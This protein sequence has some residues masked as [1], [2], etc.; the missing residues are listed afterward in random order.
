[1]I[2]NSEYHMRIDLKWLDI[3]SK[4]I[5]DAI[6]SAT[7]GVRFRNDKDIR[8]SGMS[9]RSFA[10]SLT[11]QILIQL[12]CDLNDYDDFKSKIRQ[13]SSS[14]N[15]P[16]DILKN[17]ADIKYK[18]DR[19]AHQRLNYTQTDHGKI[20]HAFDQ[21]IPLLPD[22]VQE[23]IRQISHP[24]P[25]PPPQHPPGPKLALGNQTVYTP[26]PRPNEKSGAVYQP[27]PKPIW[28]KL[29]AVAVAVLAIPTILVVQS[30]DGC[31][32]QLNCPP[33]VVGA[34][35]LANEL[36]FDAA[37]RGTATYINLRNTPGLSGGVITSVMPGTRLI[38]T[39]EAFDPS[40][41][42]WYRVRA[43]DGTVGYVK[44]TVLTG[45]IGISALVTVGRA[46]SGNALIGE[47]SDGTFE[48]GPGPITILVNYQGAS[49]NSTQ[50]RIWIEGPSGQL[51]PCV[52]LLQYSSGFQ[53]CRYE[54]I[55]LGN[56]RYF[57]EFAGQTVA[58][59]EFV[60]ENS[61][62]DAA[63]SQ[64][65]PSAPEIGRHD[66]QVGI[67]PGSAPA[68]SHSDLVAPS[69][70]EVQTP[71]SFP[72]LPSEIMENR[73]A[74]VV[75][76][77]GIFRENNG[78]SGALAGAA[79]GGATG[80]M[81][82]KQKG[83]GERAAAGAIVGGIIGAIVDESKKRKPIRLAYRIRWEDDGTLFDFETSN[84]EIFEVN[85]LVNVFERSGIFVIKYDV[86]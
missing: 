39:H 60:I 41:V 16:A 66:D 54:L 44:D 46:M 57:A 42:R 27:T 78:R 85:S 50:S 59:G 71:S 70:R 33:I 68:D 79:V 5:G 29:L 7:R 65:Q 4:N 2:R 56:W 26:R 34:Q 61:P 1:M 69:P 12:N 82:G 14:G 30:R 28:R 20:W 58:N 8:I 6:T 64:F 72:T 76:V 37:P 23:K 3:D 63:E 11:E 9:L 36:Q 35:A 52:A 84:T 73:V 62:V 19:A 17:I 75:S 32:L 38:A 10:E 49:A 81:M 86:R 77:K 55:G 21:L 31:G 13:I 18:G 15:L 25:P 22:I 74:R 24:S 53:W 51:R 40:G 48:S 83:R 80:A 47:E 67:I 43:P 45:V